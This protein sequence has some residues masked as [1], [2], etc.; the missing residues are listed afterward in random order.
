MSNVLNFLSYGMTAEQYAELFLR[1]VIAGLCGAGIGFE[2][3]RRYK[4]AG[5]RTHII[6]CM[7]SS[8]VMIL[9]RFAFVAG[10]ISL[11]GVPIQADGARL[12][13]QVVSGISFLCAGVIFKNGN[14]IKGLTTAAGI[15]AT[16][17]IGLSIGAGMY[18]LG[19][20][21]T[22]MIMLIQIL[23]HK[24]L[25][26]PDAMITQKIRVVA[27]SSPEIRKLLK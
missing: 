18:I 26:G 23:M 12:A 24:F 7:A 17:G 1:I 20:G 14:T 19:I 22:V 9:S 11:Y 5:I 4:E 21:V 27:A 2:R 13:A 8:L 25:F 15:F 16:A 10:N 6:V 3:S